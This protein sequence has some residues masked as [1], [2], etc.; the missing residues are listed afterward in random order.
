MKG[1]YSMK[2]VL[3]LALVITF[4]LGIAGCGD[5][6]QAAQSA[7]DTTDPVVSKPQDTAFTQPSQATGEET[8]PQE[9][10][11]YEAYISTVLKGEYRYE[12]LDGDGEEELFI[13][14]SIGSSEIVTVV[15][16]EIVKLLDGYHLFLCEGGI[17][18]RYGE[19]AG[20]QTVVYYRIE[21]HEAV[22]VD[23]IMAQNDGTW[24]QGAVESV[25]HVS[26]KNMTRITKEEVQKVIEQYVL[27]EDSV[28]WYLTWLYGEE[29]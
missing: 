5:V 10:D 18:G 21:D 29:A 16:G 8:E 23:A 13:T 2:K 20:G 11:P 17:I 1:E 28:P 7:A 22:I 19:G 12:D 6:Q 25:T 14:R 27:L 4:V 9:L 15:D 24:Y 3:A 26:A